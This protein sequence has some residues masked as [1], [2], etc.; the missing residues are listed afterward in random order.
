MLK[1]KRQ[2][3]AGFTLIE[4][5]MV[6]AIIGAL[7][8]IM[9][10]QLP[11]GTK[12]ARD[13]TRRSDFNQ[14]RTAL[15]TFANSNDGFYPRDTSANGDTAEGALC[16]HLSLADCPEDPK[17]GGVV[18]GD[19]S[20]NCEY[21]YQTNDC[22]TVDGDACATQYIL[23]ARLELADDEDT[24]WMVCSNGTSGNA[25]ETDVPPT[26]VDIGDCQI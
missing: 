1:I 8:G 10:I 6:M 26:G 2:P 13:S 20:D 9:V 4:L 3:R 19:G 21:L 18:C 16:G 25:D 11:A 7:A 22:G 24:F 23:W 14:Y 12:R 5:I 15:E 17:N